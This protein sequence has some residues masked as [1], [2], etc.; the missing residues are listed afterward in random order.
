MIDDEQGR[1]L[2]D[3]FTRGEPLTGEEQASLQTWYDAQDQ[4]EA[5]QLGVAISHPDL[6]GL[7]VR[8]DAALAQ[9]QEVTSQIRQLSEG[10][11][12][13]R[14]ETTALRRQLAQESSSKA[15]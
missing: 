12:A 4:A 14:R 2:H 13:L 11:E 5:S 10:N 15:A 8:V 9:L 6:A 1:E 7:R 3:R